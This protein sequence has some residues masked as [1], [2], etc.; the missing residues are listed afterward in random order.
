M[1]YPVTPTQRDICTAR[2]VFAYSDGKTIDHD[3]Y[4]DL[5]TATRNLQHYGTYGGH[6]ATAEEISPV[7]SHGRPPG[8]CTVAEVRTVPGRHWGDRARYDVLS[9]CVHHPDAD[10]AL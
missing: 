7:C 8:E 3:I 6:T 4:A 10:G 9:V 5:E 2:V 1:G